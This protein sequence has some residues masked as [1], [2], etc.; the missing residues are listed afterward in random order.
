M[1]SSGI[2]VKSA[3]ESCFVADEDFGVQPILT[4]GQI[5]TVELATTRCVGSVDEDGFLTKVQDHLAQETLAEKLL[6]TIVARITGSDAGGKLGRDN[7]NVEVF[8]NNTLGT[9]GGVRSLGSLEG[10]FGLHFGA[11]GSGWQV[12][13]LDVGVQDVRFPADPCVGQSPTGRCGQRPEPRPNEIS[14]EFTGNIHSGLGI[15]LEVDWLALEPKDEPGL[16]WRPFLLVHGWYSS[17]RNLDAAEMGP[18]TAWADGLAARDVASYAPELGG[19]GT[20]ATNAAAIGLAVAD[21]KNRFGVERIN[22]IGHDKGGI[23]TRH[24]VRDHND[25]ETLVMLATPNQGS[26]GA[27][28]LMSTAWWGKA[29]SAQSI[30]EMLRIRMLAYNALCSVRNT[31]TRYVAYSSVYDSMTA[32][33]WSSLF[34]P[35]DEFVEETSVQ[36]LPYAL[37][38]L[39]HASTGDSE[40]RRSPHLTNH[41][42]LRHYPSIVDRLFPLYLTRL[43]APPAPVSDADAA[44]GQ[45]REAEAVADLQGVVSDTAV[46]PPGGEVGS[47][48]VVIDAVDTALFYVV[49][50]GDP[51]S[52]EAD[53]PGVELV[54]PSGRR[55][56]AATPLTDPAV[57]HS[58]LLDTGPFYYTG[59][60]LRDPETGRWTLEVSGTGEPSDTTYGVAVLAHLPPGAGVVMQARADAEVYLAGAPVTIAATVT[61]D[62]LPITGAAMRALVVHPDGA[63]TDI[64]LTDDDTGGGGE[65]TGLFTDTT[66]IG[67]YAAVV[68]AE[69]DSPAFARQQPL[70]ISVVPSGTTFSG[71]FSDHGLDTDA[72]GRYDHL[73]IDV[74]LNV[75][76]AAA[77]R[78]FGTLTDSAGTTIEQICTDQHLQPGPQTTPLTF[79]GALL[80]ALGHDGPYL[81]DSLMIEDV[82]TGT[83]L[84]RGPAYTTAAYSH[85]DFQRPPFL[86]TGRTSDHGA[87]A[88]HMDRLPYE[89]LIIEVEVDGTAAIDI[90]AVAKLYAQDG[91]FIT[92]VSALATLTPGQG[93]LEFDA[94]AHNIFSTGKPGPYTLKLF[95]MWGTTTDGVP[96]SLRIDDTVAVTQPYH[97]EDFA[98]SP[99][100]TVGGIVT[101][102]ASIGQL[103]LELTAH[104]R[105]GSPTARIKPRNGFF[106]F[107]FHPIVSGNTY[108]VRVL[109]QPTN[110]AQICTIAN[111]SGTIEDANIT[112][113][114]VECT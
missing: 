29:L 85:T 87:H 22:V 58:P 9:G 36:A 61:A 37:A 3:S 55:I 110:P 19:G 8:V 99:V 24:Y 20:I 12:F 50:D 62:G 66:L 109:K 10:D 82:A 69:G 83:S 102:L 16:A 28:M 77:Y 51:P 113:I 47:H 13:T 89:A 101:G 57:V 60:Q 78:L 71:M 5:V 64:V 15:S 94:P 48:T 44:I 4:S 30:A 26:F 27:F 54:S 105:F 43:T 32:L 92:T 18:G 95:S 70:V 67:L 68:I 53:L 11:G 40:S 23:D 104:N 84:A 41:S 14:F 34:G 52:V 90:E 112:D 7:V 63:I 91:T 42:C 111:A 25:V 46:V 100:Y 103:E 86:L 97:L 49:L 31:Q 76:V 1:G 59:Y 108:Q 73:V 93:T 80:A 6:L 45:A 72:D 96:V 79:D 98:E 81:L 106:S 33:A 88:E 2:E 38:E 75:D 56:D 65:H 21:L 107:S 35:N 74:G 114:T 17:A 39:G